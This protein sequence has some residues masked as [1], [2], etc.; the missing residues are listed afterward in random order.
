MQDPA[1]Y[2]N[3]KTTKNG[4][5]PAPENHPFRFRFRSRVRYR[6]H[7]HHVPRHPLAPKKNA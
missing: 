5:S 6:Y 3:E 2:E 7:R 1:P 4:P